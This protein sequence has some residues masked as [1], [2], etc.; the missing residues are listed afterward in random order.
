MYRASRRRPFRRLLLWLLIALFIVAG[1]AFATNRVLTLMNGSGDTPWSL[2]LVNASHA[3]PRSWDCELTELRGG[4]SVDSRIV[5]DLQAMFDACREAGL[6]PIVLSGYRTTE[7]Q[8][9]EFDSKV[10]AYEAEG[11]S[12]ADAKELAALTV[13]QPGHSEHQLGLAVDIASE[14]TSVCTD[15]QVWDWMA[16]HCA[17]YGFILRYPQGKEGVTGYSYEPWHLRYVGASAA[18]TITERSITLEEY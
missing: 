2:T 5:P 16:A 13:A 1:S 8:Q 14:D 15:Q 17:D 9:A 4:Q 18:Q 3:L 12:R 6:A 10:A 11:H 7:Q